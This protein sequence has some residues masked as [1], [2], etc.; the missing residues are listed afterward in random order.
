MEPSALAP[1]LTDAKE[2]DVMEVAFNK[3]RPRL[4][5]EREIQVT[6]PSDPGAWVCPHF[7][8]L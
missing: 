8:S 6:E 4:Y 7:P 2:V 3:T 5:V 1:M